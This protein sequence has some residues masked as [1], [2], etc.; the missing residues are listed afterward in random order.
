MAVVMNTLVYADDVA[1]DM[2]VLRHE[3]DLNGCR[4]KVEDGVCKK[5]GCSTPGVH[6]FLA[7]LSSSRIESRGLTSAS[8]YP[9]FCKFAG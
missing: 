9:D 3:K 5:C 1:H 4:R 8:S 6:C 7:T 2:L